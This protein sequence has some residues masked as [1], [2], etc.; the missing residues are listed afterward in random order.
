M[1]AR[2]WRGRVPVR[3]AAAFERHLRRTGLSDYRAHAG[4][5]DVRLWR[6]EADG[7]THFMLTSVWDSMD[8]IRRYAGPEPERAV[9]YPGDDAFG[10]VPDTTVEHFDV[11]STDTP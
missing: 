1:I 4:C 6:R 11:L 5:L 8:S 2:T 3:H 10:L 7:W 9:L